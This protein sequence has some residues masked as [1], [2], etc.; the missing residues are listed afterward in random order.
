[1]S[2]IDVTLGNDSKR[3][4][5]LSAVLEGYDEGTS[6]GNMLEIIYKKIAVGGVDKA[7]VC[8]VVAGP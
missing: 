6:K 7:H 8:G 3:N 5:I 2:A 4:I 1:V